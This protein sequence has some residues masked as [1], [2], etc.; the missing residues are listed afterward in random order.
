MKHC[1]SRHR[2]SL[3]RGFWTHAFAV[4]CLLPSALS[5]SSPQR[6][7]SSNGVSSDEESG[8]TDGTTT[9]A[10]SRTGSE[11]G[12]VGDSKARD[13]SGTDATPTDDS[14]DAASTQGEHT[15]HPANPTDDVTQSEVSQPLDSSGRTS[16]TASSEQPD[17]APTEAATSAPSSEG[18][19]P[20]T[21][22]PAPF[23][24]CPDH[25]DQLVAG[26]CGCGHKP[27]PKCEALRQALRH[28]YSFVSHASSPGFD[29]SVIPDSV[30]SADGTVHGGTYDWDGS[31]RLDGQ[32]T[33]VQLPPGLLS[34]GK[35]ATLDLW[36]KWWGGGDNQR[37]LNFGARPSGSGAP[38]NYLSISPKGSEGVLTVQ[39]RTDARSSGL[40]L[41]SSGSLPTSDLEHVTVVIGERSL[42]LFVDGKRHGSVETKHKL[43]DLKDNDNFLGRALYSE[44]PRYHGALFEV[45]IFS[46]A[47]ADDEVKKLDQLGLALP[48]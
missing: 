46:R 2:S 13:A 3:R 5:C 16:P 15:S 42:S 29:G 6:F 22:E 8:S 40:R 38:D 27:E 20:S 1:I 35:E 28:R 48:Q 14:D 24:E 25:D 44:Y 7:A 37:V 47:L 11:S 17:V 41:E 18:S 45:R 39:Y 33:Y 30:G 21:S 19:T 9:A 10:G 12:S 23:D 36:V 26:S 32:T 4:F 34:S 43:T 31:L